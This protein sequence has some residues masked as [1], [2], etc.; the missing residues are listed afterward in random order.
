MAEIFFFVIATPQPDGFNPGGDRR[1]KG[2]WKWK[3][4]KSCLSMTI[5]V[6]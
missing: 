4:L 5:P 1:G 2:S 3:D 6:F